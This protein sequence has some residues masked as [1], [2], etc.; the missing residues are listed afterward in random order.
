MA[1][2]VYLLPALAGFALCVLAVR[3]LDVRTKS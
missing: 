3:A 1:D 2:L